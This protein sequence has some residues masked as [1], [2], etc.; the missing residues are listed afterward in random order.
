[1]IGRCFRC[2]RGMVGPPV[3]VTATVPGTQPTMRVHR[4]D[5]WQS[6]KLPPSRAVLLCGRCVAAVADE[7]A[8]KPGGQAAVK[9]A[10]PRGRHARWKISKRDPL[11]GVAEPP[12]EPPPDPPKGGGPKK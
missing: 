1:M 2:E 11:A 3:R 8:G 6:E 12:A 4:K 10:V 9:V 5:H 7:A